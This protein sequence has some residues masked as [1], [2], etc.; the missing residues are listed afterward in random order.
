VRV[1]FGVGNDAEI[2]AELTYQPLEQ[3]SRKLLEVTLL[4]NLTSE[5]GASY[6]RQTDPG[7]N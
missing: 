4:D 6:L 5:T 2:F 7:S 3:A 1:I